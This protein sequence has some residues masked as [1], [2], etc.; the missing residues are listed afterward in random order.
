MCVGDSA[1]IPVTPSK[2]EHFSTSSVDM[3]IQ[4]EGKE[5][6]PSLLFQFS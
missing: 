6:D 4:L 3:D 2:L 5:G 1:L